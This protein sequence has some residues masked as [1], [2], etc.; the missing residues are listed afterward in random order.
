[1]SYYEVQ[2]NCFYLSIL[3]KIKHKSHEIGFGAIERIRTQPG[4]RGIY[5]KVIKILVFFI[6]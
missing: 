3:Y 5:Q 4:A 2:V 6:C 1:M